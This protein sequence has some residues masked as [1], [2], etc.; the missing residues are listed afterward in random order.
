MR[1]KSCQ[2]ALNILV[3]LRRHPGVLFE[4]ASESGLVGKVQLFGHFL[5][6]EFGGNQVMLCMD[7]GDFLRRRCMQSTV[8]GM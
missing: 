2:I 7:D 6:A 1:I 3:F 5:D 4:I 8:L